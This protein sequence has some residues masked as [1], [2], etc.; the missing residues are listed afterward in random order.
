MKEIVSYGLIASVI[1]G[2]IGYVFAYNVPFS[3]AVYTL[4]GFGFYIFGIWAA[5]LLLKDK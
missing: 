5:V 1:A 3:E 4:A 2:L